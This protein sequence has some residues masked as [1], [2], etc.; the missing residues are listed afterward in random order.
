[1]ND[2]YPIAFVGTTLLL[3][4]RFEMGDVH[5]LV[6]AAGD[7]HPAAAQGFY[8]VAGLLAAIDERLPR[9]VLSC[10]FSACGQPARQ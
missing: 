5:T 8:Y 7:D 2:G 10:A 6:E 1:M 9:S 3:K 4:N